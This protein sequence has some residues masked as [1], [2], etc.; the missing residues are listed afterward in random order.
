MTDS[1]TSALLF[2]SES[3]DI[4][5]P[6]F[7]PC[8]SLITVNTDAAA[9]AG[10]FD[11]CASIDASYTHV[12]CHKSVTLLSHPPSTATAPTHMFKAARYMRYASGFP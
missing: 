3:V 4:P 5:H 1:L 12:D 2:R 7:A 11:G 8:L 9:D 10:A 6:V